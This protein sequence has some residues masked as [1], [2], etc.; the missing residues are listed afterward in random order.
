MSFFR[1]NLRLQELV[2]IVQ[3]NEKFFRDFLSFLSENGYSN[4]HQFIREDSDQ[5]ALEIL[6]QYLR[7]QGSATL[8]DGLLRP[9]AGPKARWYFLA[10]MMR[11]APA[12][13]LN[14]LVSGTPGKD[15]NERR[16]FLL[17]EVRKF[18]V[19]L[20]PERESWDWP[21]ISEVM[22]ARLEGSRRA[23]KG[24]LFEGIIRTRLVAL[25]R[26][27]N[28]PLTVGERQIRLGGETYDVQV[29][30]G[31]STIL[32]PV[33]TRE[34]MGGGHAFLYSRDIAGPIN[35]AEENGYG[36]IPIVIAESWTG[37]L[38]TMS[39]KRYVWIQANPNEVTRVESELAAKLT[40]LLPAFRDLV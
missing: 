38:D 19:P 8:Y 16:A 2:A 29:S 35:I 40:E 30:G 21:A 37:D 25:F 27:E 1:E 17:N 32:L 10:W 33:K 12:Q 5:R 13:R 39:S 4:L 9:Y 15:V 23:L 24:T 31:K 34:T 20:F 7:R 26:S 36:C 14:P 11:D 28:L 6:D 18:V 3:E 22:L